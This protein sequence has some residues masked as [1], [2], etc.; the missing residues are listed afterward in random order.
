MDCLLF[1][2]VNWY[3]PSSAESAWVKTSVLYTRVLPHMAFCPVG[4]DILCCCIMFFILNKAQPHPHPKPPHTLQT[5]CLSPLWVMSLQ[6]SRGWEAGMLQPVEWGKGLW[7]EEGEEDVCSCVCL[8][9]GF[10]AALP[11]E[12]F[13]SAQAGHIRWGGEAFSD[14]SDKSDKC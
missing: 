6:D 13:F 7:D 10:T 14:Q 1:F 8:D 9:G 11:C 2:L 4:W 12:N 3:Y 5:A